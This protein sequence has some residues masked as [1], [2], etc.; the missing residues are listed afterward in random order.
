M[1]SVAYRLSNNQKRAL[2]AGDSLSIAVPRP[3]RTPPSWFN[4]CHK[5]L[6]P[7]GRYLQAVTP[8]SVLCT[9]PRGTGLSSVIGVICQG[10]PYDDQLVWSIDVVVCSLSFNTTRLCNTSRVQWPGKAVAGEKEWP[11]PTTACDRLND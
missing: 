1:S 2:R 10:D 6:G 7:D 3:V 4:W 5:V 9:T 11:F 8:S